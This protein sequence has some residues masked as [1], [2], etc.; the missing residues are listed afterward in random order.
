MQL[1][2]RYKERQ[3]RPSGFSGRE[4]PMTRRA[5]AMRRILWFSRHIGPME[6]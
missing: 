3:V 2:R 4:N 1:A 6:S 5:Q